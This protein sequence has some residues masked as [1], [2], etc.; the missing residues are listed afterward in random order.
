MN[1]NN[2]N[3]NEIQKPFLSK[4][5]LDL[6]RALEMDDLLEEDLEDI[7]GGIY[8]FGS[9][10]SKTVHISS[11]VTEETSFGDQELS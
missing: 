5:K 11:Q 4:I 9:A 6:E 2:I 8:G 1:N 10:E 3:S 7:A